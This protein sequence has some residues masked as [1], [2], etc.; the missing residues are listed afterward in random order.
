MNRLKRRLLLTFYEIKCTK[1]QVSLVVVFLLL[2]F[3]VVLTLVL[4]SFDF[5]KRDKKETKT[6][7]KCTK[8]KEARIFKRWTKK[9][10]L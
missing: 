8:N 6:K 4:V 9:D 1:K 3:Y 2:P 5:V 10:T 7:V